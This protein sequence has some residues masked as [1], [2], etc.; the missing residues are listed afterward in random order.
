MNQLLDVIDSTVNNARSFATQTEDESFK[1]IK[2]KEC[3]E[4]A[5]DQLSYEFTENNI[6]LKSELGQDDPLVMA[7]PITLQQIFV[8][9]FRIQMKYLVAENI[10]SVKRKIILSMADNQSKWLGI[11]ITAQSETNKNDIPQVNEITVEE[12]F[13]FDLN[14]VKLIAESLGGDFNWYPQAR[15]GFIFSLRIPID[16]DDERAQLRNMIELFHDA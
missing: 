2:I 11:M 12:T 1:I 13:D 3:I 4:N 7:N 6:A 8:T 9:L 10:Q 14:V 16:S 15:N 5:I